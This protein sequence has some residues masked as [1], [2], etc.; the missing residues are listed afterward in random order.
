MFKKSVR[1]RTVKAA[2]PHT[3]GS[4]IELCGH[5]VEKMRKHTQEEHFNNAFVK[6]PVWSMRFRE[7]KA[8]FFVFRENWRGCRIHDS[9]ND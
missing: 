3:V 7:Q 1:R 8:R 2:H 5:S 4:P 9:C 6:V